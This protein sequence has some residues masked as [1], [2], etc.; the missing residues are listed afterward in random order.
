MDG[1]NL[2]PDGRLQK[3]I[4]GV[5]ELLRLEKD[6]KTILSKNPDEWPEDIREARELAWMKTKH[7]PAG[8]KDK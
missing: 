4:A 6:G 8:G 3:G 2:E 5:R 7:A 1:A